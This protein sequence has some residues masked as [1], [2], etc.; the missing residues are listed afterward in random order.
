MDTSGLRVAE[1][2]R[3]PVKSLAG[4]RLDRAVV[5]TNG[6]VGD[7]VVHVRDRRDRVVTARNRPRLLALH[8]TLGPDGEP[9]IDGR[10]WTAPNPRRRCARPPAPE[11]T[12]ARYDGPERF[13]VLPLLV[14][15]DGAIAA[16]GVDGRRLRPNIVIG[17]VA[18]VAERQW[19]G[20]RLRIGDVVISME[21][22]R[23]RCVMTTWDPDTQV[24]DLSVLRRIVETS[25]GRWR[26]TPPSCP[27]GRS[28]SAI[29]WRSARERPHRLPRA[30][31]RDH[32]NGP[33]RTR[34]KLRRRRRLFIRARAGSS[35]PTRRFH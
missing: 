24:Q 1:L 28:R 35:E 17:G 19:P 15:T 29:P 30:S 5:T 8:G 34:Q 18:G 32:T 27:A 26:W 3:Y 31:A 12:L 16:L 33:D 6:I 20:R 2:W 22:L 14:A 7:R 13:D 4:E 11:A 9:L 23:G 21:K 25:T 10:P